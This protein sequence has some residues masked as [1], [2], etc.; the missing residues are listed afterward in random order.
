MKNFIPFVLVTVTAMYSGLGEALPVVRNCHRQMVEVR[1]NLGPGQILI[2]HCVH[3]I[4]RRGVLKFNEKQQY[5]AGSGNARSWACVLYK[6]PPTDRYGIAVGKNFQKLPC[7]TGV[8]AWIAKNDGVYF[9]G[10]GKPMKFL[11]K[12]AKM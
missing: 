3:P 6:G 10:N 11:N 12:W 1:N 7:N 9:E 8:L 4:V 5:N 2:F